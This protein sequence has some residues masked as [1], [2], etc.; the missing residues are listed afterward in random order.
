MLGLWSRE[1]EQTGVQAQTR[2]QLDRFLEPL[3]TLHQGNGS[4]PAISSQ[5]DLSLRLPAAHLVE[6]T[7][8]PLHNRAVT[9]VESGA[10]FLS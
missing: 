3:T 2:D 5:D 4:I 6:H 8:S 7:F 1:I 10:G 9:F